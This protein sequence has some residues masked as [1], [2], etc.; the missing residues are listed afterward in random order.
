VVPEDPPYQDSGKGSRRPRLADLTCCPRSVAAALSKLFLLVDAL[1]ECQVADRCLTTFL[2]EIF[3]LQTT[4]N[5]CV[6]ATTRH[7]PEIIDKFGI[8]QPVETRAS[9]DD[10]RTYVDANMTDLLISV[11]C[12]VDL[13]DQIKTR[14]VK[15][16]DGM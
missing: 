10:I 2:A 16:A 14:I 13:Q 7:V 5:T 15:S 11:Q 3:H 12:S 1:D 9:S 8:D 6:L 4:S